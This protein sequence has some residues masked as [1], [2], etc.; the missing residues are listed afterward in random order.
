M[1][2]RSVRKQIKL[3]DN[4]IA[5][6]FSKMSN[7]VQ[8]YN[9]L[10][11]EIKKDYEVLQRK[12]ADELLMQMD[13]EEINLNKEGI[14]VVLLR[15]AGYNNVYQLKGKGINELARINGLGL[16]NCQKI[17]SNFEKLYNNALETAVVKLD[18]DNKSP[19]TNALIKKIYIAQKTKKI[20]DECAAY[21]NE[22]SP[23]LVNWSNDV[24]KDVKLFKWIFSGKAKKKKITEDVE[25][26]SSFVTEDYALKAEKYSIDFN[27]AK[28]ISVESCWEEFLNNSATFYVSL[29]EITGA[30]TI[31]MNSHGNTVLPDELLKEIEAETLDLEFL[32][33]TLRNYQ[34]FG[35]KY[36]IHQK[37]TLLG[38]EMGLGKTMQAIA[39]I[40]HLAKQGKQRF[41]VV[42]PLS[43]LVNWTREIKKFTSLNVIDIY[44]ED[45]DKEYSLWKDEYYVG[46]TTYETLKK[47]DFAAVDKIDLLIV[48]EAHYIKNPDA[49]RTKNVSKLNAIADSV[50]YMTGTPLE[51]SIDE[52]KSLIASV[53]S[54]MVD[55]LQKYDKLSSPS[56]FRKAIAP[57]YLRRT[58][59]EVLKELPELITKEDW[60]IMN[61]TESEAYTESL[62]NEAFMSVRRVSWNIKDS[63]QCSKAER[64]LDICE[65]A[66]A[67][68]RKI[69]VFSYF[70]DTL[71]YVSGLLGEKCVGIITGDVP[72]THRQE[73]V[74][75]FTNAGSGSVLVAQVEA[76]GV[77]LNIQAASI[78]IFCEPQLKPSIENQAISRA[79]R[80]GQAR[81]VVVHKLLMTDSIDERIMEMLKEK[82]ELFDKF[83][84]E[85]AIAQEAKKENDNATM[86]NMV[87]DE[88]KRL[89]LERNEQAPV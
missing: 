83:A 26:C 70:R 45:C 9:A 85:S 53:N 24:K 52:M 78:V 31:G 63:S 89:G 49:I 4:M 2:Y 41:L 42:C 58:R 62:I 64:L 68:D 28:N 25:K 13:I 57:V 87:D 67:D 54:S 19:E 23:K 60:L 75:K 20:A 73:L 86:K 15:D 40:A 47:L 71:S 37:R 35:T 84:D 46:V 69:I 59:D 77:G 88:L 16:D 11:A 74:D 44:A 3:N 29:E 79:Y 6:S 56:E 8:Q 1:S 82:Q 27:N 21:C 55:T 81:S 34:T 80:M 17:V 76:G 10:C 50:L 38:D 43:V 61:T 22:M 14:R 51:N 5:A 12:K 48:D 30:E 66:A 18:Y 32:N 36:I 65:E 72:S 39:A 7:V 33:A